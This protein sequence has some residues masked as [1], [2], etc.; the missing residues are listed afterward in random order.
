MRKTIF[1]DLQN[2]ILGG[3][4]HLN[5]EQK[6]MI[7]ILDSKHNLFIASN[8]YPSDMAYFNEPARVLQLLCYKSRLPT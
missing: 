1:L 8:V 5:Q 3:I 2:T 4:S 7:N 6:E